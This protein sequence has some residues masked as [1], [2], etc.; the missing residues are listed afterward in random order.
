MPLDVA[1][2]DVVED[3]VRRQRILIGLVRPQLR[4]RRLRQARLRNDRAARASGSA[5]ARRGRPSS[6]ARR[7]SRRG[8][9]TCRRTACSSR[10]RAPTCCRSSAAARR[11]CST[12][13]SAGCRGCAPGCSLRSTSRRGPANAS[14]ERARRIARID[15]VDRQRQRLDAEVRRQLPRIVDAAAARVR[16]RHQHAEHVIARRAPRRRS[17]RS[18]PSRCRPTGRARRSRKPHLR[19]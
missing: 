19:A 2:Q 16:R 12:A 18:A 5:S 11:A 3:V 17:R 8:R 9:R 6:S 14:R 10:P 7:R 15:V 4:R 1:L 13:P